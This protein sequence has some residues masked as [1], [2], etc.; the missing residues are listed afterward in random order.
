MQKHSTKPPAGDEPGLLD[1]YDVSVAVHCSVVVAEY[2]CR[3]GMLK[4]H[5]KGIMGMRVWRIRREDLDAFMASA[6]EA[7]GSVAEFHA[8]LAAAREARERSR[9]MLEPKI[10]WNGQGDDE[11]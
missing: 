4:A 7:A 2:L 10:D 3:T 5:K 9:E 11:L 6:S 1:L 8:R